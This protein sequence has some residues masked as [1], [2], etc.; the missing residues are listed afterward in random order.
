[1]ETQKSLH[2]RRIFGASKE[3]VYQAWTDPALLAKWWGP[4][5]FTNPTC[6]IEVKSGG[7]IHI[8]MKGPEGNIYPMKG[9]IQEVIPN[10]K[11]SFRA[12]AAEDENGNPLLET[13]NIVTFEEVNGI[14]IMHLDVHVVTKTPQMEPALE[15]MEQ[16][17][18]E[19]LY[20]LGEVLDQIH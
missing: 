10:A 2:V 3:L 19:S 5:Q 12:V 7:N 6:E 8:D 1:M 14:C 9:T 13:E 4:R 11:L 15:G 16:G 18:S 20:K 17:W